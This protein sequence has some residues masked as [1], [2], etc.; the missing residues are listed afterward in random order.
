MPLPNFPQM[1]LFSN[2]NFEFKVFLGEVVSRSFRPNRAGFFADKME[3]GR[4]F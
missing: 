3:Y 4:P 2:G 1:S